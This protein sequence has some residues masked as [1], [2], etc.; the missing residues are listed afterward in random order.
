MKKT[1]F[2]L[3]GVLI[4]LSN[5]AIAVTFDGTELLGC[6]T[7]NSVTVNVIA[8]TALDVYFEYGTESGVYT[9]QTSTISSVADEPIEVVIDGLEPNTKYYYRMVYSDNGGSTWV[10]RDEHSFYT[11]R[12]QGSTFTFTIIA[13]SHIDIMLGDPV[14]YERTLENVNDDNPDFHI[15]LGDTFAMDGVDTWTQAQQAYL[16]HRPYL[17]IISHSAPIFLVI[18]NHENEEGWNLDDTPSQ[19]IFS[20]NARKLYYPTPIPDDFYSGN[21]DTSLADVDGDHLR[22]DYY[23]WEW[24]DALFVVLD[25]FQYTMTNPYGASAGEENDEGPATH[26]RWDWTLGEQQYN[27]LKETLENSDATYKLVFSHHVTGGT[28]DYVRGGA[29]AVPYC[30]WGGY[31]VDGVTWAF[32]TERPGWDEPVHQLMVNN[33]VSA[34]FHGHDHEYAYE[35]RDGIVY[36]LV[37]APSMTG[38]GFNLYSESDPYTIKVLPNSG[39]LR[40]TV[41]STEA[42]VDYVSSSD[43]SNGDVVYSYTIE[44]QAGNQTT[45]NLTLDVDPAGTGTTNPAIGTHTYTENSIVTINAIPASGYVFD[46]WG[47]DV[48]DPDAASTTVTMDENQEVTAHFIESSGEACSYIMDIGTATAQT[49]GTT[50]VITTTDAV[51]EGDDIIIAYATYGDPNYE[52]SIA[53]DAGNDY[54]QVAMSINYQHGRTYLFAAYDVNALPSGSEITITHTSVAARA[55]VASV[56]RGLADVDPLDKVLVNP[57]NST[58]DAS[59]TPSVGPTDTTTEAN[60]LLIGAIGTEGPVTDDPG[61]WENSFIAGQ[62]EGTDGA[63][64][65]WTI[66]MGYRIVSE[67]GQYTAQKSGITSRRWAAA[68]AT[69]KAEAIA[70]V[71]NDGDGYG[72]PAS[73]GCTYPEQ[74]C[75][76]TNIDV[77]PGATEIHNGVD[78]NCNGE[79]DEGF[80]ET[81]ADTNYDGEIDM[82][83][84]IAYI[85][86]WYLG[87][88]DMSDLMNAIGYWKAGVG[89]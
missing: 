21:D 73:P 14:L 6:P 23:A 33:G 25:P 13:D 82:P 34:F 1:I 59:T 4:I 2:L 55:A 48:A 18:G 37:P 38:Y 11:Q 76:D 20:I 35:E 50:L 7:D 9:G 63:S 70:C 22:E 85:G 69:F 17:D 75:D 51:A 65:D 40:V 16:N 79:I 72:N 12:A 53:D 44:P 10:N 78:D 15:D 42:T 24:G 8:D 5:I 31:N 89:C 45:Y 67:T 30:E 56:F 62:R 58:L 39:H 66:S 3:L 19:A 60:E 80:C 61:I 43:G 41:T 36:Q 54:E 28:Q 26:D 71:D 32:D 88:I 29:E 74:D 83:E 68:I 49:T 87:E 46:Y 81:D 47:G 27:W 64:N 86:K 57:N 52:I 84:L 77:N